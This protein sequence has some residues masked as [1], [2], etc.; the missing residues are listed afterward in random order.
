M[1]LYL[2]WPIIWINVDV[3][4]NRI[5]W[6]KTVVIFSLLAMLVVAPTILTCHIGVGFLYR[7]P[8]LM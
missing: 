1:K 4:I 8:Q 6:S 7:L 3:A 5:P 2:Q